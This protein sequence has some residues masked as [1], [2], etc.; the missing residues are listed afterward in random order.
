MVRSESSHSPE[1]VVREI[2]RMTRCKFSSDEKIQMLLEGL[3]DG[4]G[5]SL[6][7]HR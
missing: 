5:I 1:A 2:R 6:I 7:C 3:K 4:E